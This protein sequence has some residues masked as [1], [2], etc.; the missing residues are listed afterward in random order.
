MLPKTAA[1]RDY[2]FPEPR[3]TLMDASRDTLPKRRAVEG[4]TDALLIHGVAG[5]V[6]R[7]EQ[8]VAKIVLADAGGDADVASRNRVQ[9]G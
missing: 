9:K 6:Q 5:L 7:R 3:L 2:V 8:S 4:S 1:A